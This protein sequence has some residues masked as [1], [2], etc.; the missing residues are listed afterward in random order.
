MKI[1]N[2]LIHK[3]GGKTKEEIFPPT[4][5]TVTYPTV[6]KFG[7]Y[8]IDS[9]SMIPE[10]YIIERLANDFIP[11]IKENMKITKEIGNYGEKRYRAEI[12]IVKE[13]NK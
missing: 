6:E 11:M 7:T 10:E 12:S 4:Q 3:L 2:W 1:K 9:Y 13:G 8:F 5:Y